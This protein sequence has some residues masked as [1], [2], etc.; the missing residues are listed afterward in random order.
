L[1]GEEADHYDPKPTE[2][3]WYSHTRTGDRAYFVK[4][5]GRECVK[6]DRPNQEIVKPLGPEWKEDHETRPLNMSQLARICYAADQ[7]LCKALGERD[8]LK[9]WLSLRDEDVADWMSGRGPK[10]GPVE[11]RKLYASN[12]TALKGSAR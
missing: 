1:K 8:C 10:K 7:E 4:R 11:R 3:R 9:D 6:L 2:R 12:W 5:E